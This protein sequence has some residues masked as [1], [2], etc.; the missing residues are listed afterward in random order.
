MLIY[1][2]IYRIYRNGVLV[3]NGSQTTT[4]VAYNNGI[5]TISPGDYCAVCDLRI[6]SI[7]RDES[8]YLEMYQR[9]MTR[10]EQIPYNN[11]ENWVNMISENPTLNIY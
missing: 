8:Y 6:A 4:A 10:F 1:P 7:Q 5:D 2:Y 11:V 3:A 9:G